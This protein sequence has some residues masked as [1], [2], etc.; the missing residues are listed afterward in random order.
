MVQKLGKSSGRF[1]VY[2]RLYPRSN[3]LKEVLTV[4]YVRF[5]EFCLYA[6]KAFAEGKSKKARCKLTILSLLSTSY[7]LIPVHQG[8]VLGL[9]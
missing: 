3:R 4:A 1:D 7:I 9:A 5:L 6:K 8:R 2:A